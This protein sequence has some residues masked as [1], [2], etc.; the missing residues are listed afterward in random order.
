ML[1][2]VLRPLA[3]TLYVFQLPRITDRLRDRRSDSSSTSVLA[4]P[5]A[6][7]A[8]LA[9]FCL[10]VHR[11]RLRTTARLVLLIGGRRDWVQDRLPVSAASRGGTAS[12]Y[13]WVCHEDQCDLGVAHSY[14]EGLKGHTIK[15]DS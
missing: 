8:G 10:F 2:C 12:G 15:E 13:Y 9:V 11:S 6:S 5:P 3:R 4:C 7:G 1:G 14:V